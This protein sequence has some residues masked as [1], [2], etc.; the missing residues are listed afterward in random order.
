ML[1]ISKQEGQNDLRG[2]EDVDNKDMWCYKAYRESIAVVDFVYDLDML[3][4]FGVKVLRGNPFVGAELGARLQDPHDLRIDVFQLQAN[5]I[6]Q[7]L[8]TLLG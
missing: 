1:L 6:A 8:T 4:V 3:W 5:A 7:N 2:K